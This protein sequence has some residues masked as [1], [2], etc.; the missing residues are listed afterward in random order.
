MAALRFSQ[1]Y[2]QLSSEMLLFHKKGD[3]IE[4]LSL[5]SD[6]VA[7]ILLSTVLDHNGQSQLATGPKS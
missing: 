3:V 2:E 7:F 4:L 1:W 5:K 6:P